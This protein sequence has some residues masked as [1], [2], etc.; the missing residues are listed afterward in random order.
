MS[1]ESI[2]T[3]LTRTLKKEEEDAKKE[4]VDKLLS[5]Y[6]SEIEGFDANQ[7]T[8][9]LFWNGQEIV[10]RVADVIDG[11]NK[12]AVRS[13]QYHNL[14][15]FFSILSAAVPIIVTILSVVYEWNYYAQLVDAVFPLVVA[16]VQTKQKQWLDWSVA[17]SKV[18]HRYRV[19]LSSIIIDISTRA[20]DENAE[21][22]KIEAGKLDGILVGARVH[23]PL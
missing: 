17:I 23:L 4:R 18:D 19:L 10:E 14:I 9:W 11:N 8:Q 7:Q 16:A 22:H 20:Y 5:K 1:P 6:K 13:R 12:A 3:D 15:L 2:I 21:T